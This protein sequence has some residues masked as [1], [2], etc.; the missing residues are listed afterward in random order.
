MNRLI[1]ILVGIVGLLYFAPT[2]VTVYN[3]V[4]YLQFI[5]GVV[6]D[7]FSKL[8]FQTLPYLIMAALVGAIF[9]V[10][11]HRSTPPNE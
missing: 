7:E 1:F 2:L 4:F 8:F 9:W 3:D 6:T 5:D 10:I 11:F